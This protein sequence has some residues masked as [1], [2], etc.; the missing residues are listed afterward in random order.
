MSTHEQTLDEV[1]RYY[2]REDAYVVDP[3]TAVGLTAQA[4]AAKKG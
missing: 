3:H 4:R 1:K 2:D